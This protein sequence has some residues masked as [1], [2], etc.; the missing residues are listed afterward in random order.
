MHNH[1][2]HQM[3]QKGLGCLTAICTRPGDGRMSIA[4]SLANTLARQGEIVYF[5]TFSQTTKIMRHR[6]LPC[7]HSLPV[8]EATDDRL[9]ACLCALPKTPHTF[10]FLDHLTGMVLTEDHPQRPAKKTAIVTRLRE[11]A[12]QNGI[13]IVV[14]DLFWTARDTDDQLPIPHEALNLCDNAYIAY[15]E[16]IGPEMVDGIELPVI[17]WKKIV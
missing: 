13:H 17:Q 4:I 16:S 10:V 6:L 15:K 12:V 1:I 5:H 7:V 3:K 9:F 2:I 8:G 14:T 11:I